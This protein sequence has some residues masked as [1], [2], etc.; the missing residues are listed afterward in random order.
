[1]TG[2]LAGRGNHSFG[3]N[4]GFGKK[5]KIEGKNRLR[6]ESELFKTRKMGNWVR[7]ETTDKVL[8]TL[9]ERHSDAQLREEA[10]K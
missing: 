8:R 5:A 6:T 7:K 4:N 9:G 2:A 10:K 3:R 1:V